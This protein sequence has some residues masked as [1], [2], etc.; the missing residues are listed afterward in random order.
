MSPKCGLIGRRVAGPRYVDDALVFITSNHR[1][2]SRAVDRL[3]DLLEM[4]D[5]RSQLVPLL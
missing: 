1:A 5:E 4:S 2:C 3:Y